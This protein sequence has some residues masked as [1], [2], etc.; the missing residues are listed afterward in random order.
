MKKSIFIFIVMLNFVCCKKTLNYND[1]AKRTKSE[2]VINNEV[3]KSTNAT[4]CYLLALNKDST[5]ISLTIDKLGNVTGKMHWKPYQKDG[6]VG[7]LSGKKSNDTIIALF[8][9]IIE[10]SKQLEEKV[11]VLSDDKLIELIGQLDDKSGI[12]TIKDLKKATVRSTLTSVD[13]GMLK[14][15]N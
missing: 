6:A 10:G 5:I 1:N 2:T 13:C 3:L 8:D 9:Y 14:F 11:F 7:N 4:N 15:S 12:L